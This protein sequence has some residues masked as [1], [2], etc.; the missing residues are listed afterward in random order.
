M[1][2]Y[3][4]FDVGLRYFPVLVILWYFLSP[5]ERSQIYGEMKQVVY[6]LFILSQNIVMITIRTYHQNNN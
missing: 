6:W 5:V 4:I 3:F 2:P 1:N